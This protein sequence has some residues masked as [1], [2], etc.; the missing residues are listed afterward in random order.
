[1]P[2]QNLTG[3]SAHFTPL[4]VTRRFTSTAQSPRATI[5]IAHVNDIAIKREMSIAQSG[6]EGDITDILPTRGSK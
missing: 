3:L 4:N 6:V 1:M 5:T 2:I